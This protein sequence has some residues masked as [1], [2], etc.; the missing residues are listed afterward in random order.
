MRSSRM[1]NLPGRSVQT[2]ILSYSSSVLLS[3]LRRKPRPVGCSAR[4]WIPRGETAK[5]AHLL[6]LLVFDGGPHPNVS[7]AMLKLPR[8]VSF[9]ETAGRQ[10]A[11][12][13]APTLFRSWREWCF[14]LLESQIGAAH[15]ARFF[16][17]LERSIPSKYCWSLESHRSGRFNS[18]LP[19]PSPGSARPVCV[20]VHGAPQ[21][22][23]DLGREGF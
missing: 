5:R 11:G 16:A 15:G 13:E 12:I 17:R 8:R 19:K 20:V 1:R 22:S 6:G 23:R 3:A 7:S 4:P 10:L 21:S 2:A 14:V 9:D 18:P